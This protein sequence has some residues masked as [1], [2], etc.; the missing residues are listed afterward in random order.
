MTDDLGVRTHKVKE[1][2][3]EQ[4]GWWTV[5]MLDDDLEIRVSD[6]KTHRRV[7][8]N[9]LCKDGYIRR[10]G[11]AP[12][13]Y[14]RVDRD[15]QEINWT[16]AATDGIVEMEWPRDEFGEGTFGLEDI[17][18]YQKAVIVVSGVSNRGKGHPHGTL[19]LT[20]TGYKRIE[21]LTK[22]DWV[23]T[24]SGGFVRVVNVF[25]RQAQPCFRFTFND[26]SSII[27][28]RDHIW[29]VFKRHHRKTGHGNLSRLYNTWDE[30]TT[31]ELIEHCGIGEIRAPSR[32]RVPSVSPIQF[33]HKDTPLSPYIL[34][35]LLG[36]GSLTKTTPMISSTDDEILRSIQ[37]GGFVIKPAGGCDYRILGLVG[38]LRKMGV[39]GHW[40]YDKKIPKSYLYNDPDSRLAILQ[41]LLDSDGSISKDGSIEFS[42]CS[43]RLAQDV[44]FLVRSLGGRATIS[45]R[46]PTYS[47]KGGSLKGRVSYRVKIKINTM[48]PFRLS[49]KADKWAPS[50]KTAERILRRI[51][52]VGVMPTVCIQV[53]SMDGLYVAQDFIVSHNT[54]F[55]L[56]LA[57]VNCQK[58]DVV[59]FTNEMTAPELAY[60]L[61]KIDWVS[62]VDEDGNP[63]FRAYERFDEYEDVIVPDAINIIDYLEPAEFYEVGHIIDRLRQ[64]LTTGIV[65]IALQKKG[66]NGEVAYGVGG[67]F[68]E[69]R[70]RLVLHLNDDHLLIKKAKS[71]TGKNPNGKKYHFDLEDSI[72]FENIYEVFEEGK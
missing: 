33:A 42:S 7:I 13:T 63:R 54:A 43:N 32:V 30:L 60:R 6:Q 53:D 36:D 40:A 10:H 22:R 15:A 24:P 1:W 4:D 16:Q 72:R 47:Y 66:G 61:R 64:P 48:C 65:V 20:K 9:R 51:D 49:R 2:V 57:A 26:K 58:H 44:M 34:G 37:D 62:L 14:R 8:L 28:D 35:L 23:A 21:K 31:E 19:V 12:G 69:H 17:R 45:Q 56:N 41:G 29:K 70:A 71:Y 11:N 55:L 18:I 59:Y 38:I 52:P 25:Y 3:D 39:W 68:S 5:R 46:I 67:Q 50:K 27:A